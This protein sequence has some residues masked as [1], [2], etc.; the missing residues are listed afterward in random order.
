MGRS[1]LQYTD[2]ITEEPPSP[3]NK[4]SVYPQASHFFHQPH[5]PNCVVRGLDVQCNGL[6]LLSLA[7]CLDDVIDQTATRLHDL[8]PSTEAELVG[9][10]KAFGLQESTQTSTDKSFHDLP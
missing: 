8:L 3:L 4:M 6:D 9:G 5:L 2:S 1:N 10:Q 7:K